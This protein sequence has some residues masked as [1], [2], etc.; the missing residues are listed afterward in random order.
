MAESSVDYDTDRELQE[1][2]RKSLCLRFSKILT[3]ELG[4][5][6]IAAEKAVKLLRGWMAKKPEVR[7][8]LVSQWLLALAGAADPAAVLER[9][10]ADP[11]AGRGLKRL[12]QML[13]GAKAGAAP[14]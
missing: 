9:L 12:R 6:A 11:K 2:E 1:N 3:E 5:S 4:W 7:H 8:P 10:L 14:D 13:V